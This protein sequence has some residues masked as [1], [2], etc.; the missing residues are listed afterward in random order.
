MSLELDKN[1]KYVFIKE[2]YF[3]D[4]LKTQGKLTTIEKNFGHKYD[5]KRI[6]EVNPKSGLVDGKFYVS[7]NWCEK[8]D[9][10]KYG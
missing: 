7:Y 8:I 6:K 4:V 10:I 3:E 2:K 1:L 9:K 5:K